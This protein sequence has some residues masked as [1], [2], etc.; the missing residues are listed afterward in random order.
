MTNFMLKGQLLSHLND[1]YAAISTDVHYQPTE[2]KSMVQNQYC[3]ISEVELFCILDKLWSTTYLHGFCV[4]LRRLN[5][6][7][8]KV[9]RQWKT[10]VIIPNIS[11][12]ANSI[13][14]RPKSIT[15]ILS[16]P[17]Q[18]CVVR[19]NPSAKWTIFGL[20]DT[21]FCHS[22]ANISKMVNRSVTYQF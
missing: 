14:F 5:S 2:R 17:L 21:D 6:Q 7:L 22:T 8:Q 9:P 1:H 12:P 20:S 3:W 15:L 10:A 16:L 4:W 19:S 11:K 13:D 18:R